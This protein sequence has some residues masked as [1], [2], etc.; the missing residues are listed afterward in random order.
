MTSF[1]ALFYLRI[2]AAT[3]FI[4]GALIWLVQRDEVDSYSPDPEALAWSAIGT[5]LMGFGILVAVIT[6]ATLAI[7]EAIRENANKN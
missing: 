1:S 4:L 7:V 2:I 3:N 6:L 5:N